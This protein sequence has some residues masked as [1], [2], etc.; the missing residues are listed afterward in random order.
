MTDWSVIFKRELQRARSIRRDA[1][2][3][4]GINEENH[5]AALV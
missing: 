4:N 1:A 2:Y 3:L 5:P